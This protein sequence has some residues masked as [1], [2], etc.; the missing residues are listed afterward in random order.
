MGAADVQS[1]VTGKE[2]IGK[3]NGKEN[4]KGWERVDPALQRIVVVGR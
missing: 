1:R 2:S 3:E 4:G